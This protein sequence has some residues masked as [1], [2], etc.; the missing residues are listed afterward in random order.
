MLLLRFA[1]EPV[2]DAALADT[3]PGVQLEAVCEPA[4][5]LDPLMGQSSGPF[6]KYRTKSPV[7]NGRCGWV[8]DESFH[9]TEHGVLKLGMRP[10]RATAMRI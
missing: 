10:V 7:P 1:H 2:L 3:E 9:L 8:P 5:N 6:D 4:C